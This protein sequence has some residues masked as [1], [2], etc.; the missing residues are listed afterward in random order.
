MILLNKMKIKKLQISFLLLYIITVFAVIYIA[1]KISYASQTCPICIENG[2]LVEKQTC[3]DGTCQTSCF[4]NGGIKCE[5]GEGHCANGACDPGC[6]GYQEL[7]PGQTCTDDTF[8]GGSD[9][10][11]CTTVICLDPGHVAASGLDN[12]QQGISENDNAFKVAKSVKKKLEDDGYKV[13][14][15][16]N[17]ADALKTPDGLKL[18]TKGGCD[19]PDGIR[20]RSK[21]CKAQGATYMFSV[22]SDTAGS[23][24]YII[25]P[26]KPASGCKPNTT[27]DYYARNLETAQKIQSKVASTLGTS[28]S[29]DPGGVVI[30]GGGYV[31][32]NPSNPNCWQLNATAGA[33]NEEIDRGLIEMTPD[34]AWYAENLDLAS[35][36]IAKGL[37]SAL[38]KES[39]N[40]SCAS[41][42]CA[43][44]GQKVVEAARSQIKKTYV[45]G[46]CHVEP[47]NF[48]NGCANYD[49]TGLTGWAW[50]K[51]SN[52][53]VN[54]HGATLTGGQYAGSNVTYVKPGKD[55]AEGAQ[56]GDI[57]GWSNTSSW[58]QTYHGAIYTGKNSLIEAYSSGLPSRET[59]INGRR[60]LYFARPK[61]CK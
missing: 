6:C 36:A 58:Q 49:C 27:S 8:T 56:A 15:T 34:P 14:M 38:P 20:N 52:G 26:P 59:T 25:A 61:A 47:S 23:G 30:E 45:W 19:D 39:K 55:V 41:G 11:V 1:P 3:L 32:C 28:H 48:P 50:W 44:M 43:E 16:K 51:G 37:S 18:E 7:S 5:A 40:S 10:G 46:G 35:T 21:S 42:S 24:P 13:V 29:A 9:T 12:I 57:I 2:K 17:S 31:R 22:H 33:I 54:F 60:P 4:K 53:R